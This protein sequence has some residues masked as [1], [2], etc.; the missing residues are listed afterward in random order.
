MYTRPLALEPTPALKQ[1]GSRLFGYTG[2]T[3]AVQVHDAP[4]QLHDLQWGG[5]TKSDWMILEGE[6]A[7]DFGAEAAAYFPPTVVI[8]ITPN[9]L[10]VEHVI[11][12]GK[13]LGVRLHVHPSRL[14]KLLPEP[15]IIE[16]WELV[17]LLATRE[18]KNTYG[19]RTNIRYTEAHEV[20]GISPVEWAEA[21]QACI[22]KGWL[23]KQGAITPTGS[24]VTGT[25]SL[26]NLRKES[27]P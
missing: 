13:D 15:K 12:C 24:N 19:G 9:T 1:L 26:R 11:F 25:L 3:F 20:T 21:R 17:V 7:Y 18:Y 4:Y 22:D 5:G 14:P 2:R 6:T 8:D 16:R 23:T 10:L 27:L